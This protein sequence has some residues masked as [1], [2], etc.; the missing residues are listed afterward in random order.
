MTALHEI[1]V[2]FFVFKA[3]CEL[4]ENNCSKAIQ[5]KCGNTKFIKGNSVHH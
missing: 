2:A 1:A 5:L 3:G 4:V